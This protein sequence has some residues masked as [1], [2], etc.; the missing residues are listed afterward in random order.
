MPR[1]DAE[2]VQYN[3]GRKLRNNNESAIASMPAVYTSTPPL[4][5]FATIAAGIAIFVAP[6]QRSAGLRGTMWVLAGLAILFTYWRAGKLEHLIPPYRALGIAALA[7]LMAATI[8]SFASP[9]PLESLGAVKRDILTPML[10][11]A[12]FYALTKTRADM[13]RWLWALTLGLLVLT[14]MIVIEPFDP[15]GGM[16]ESHYITVGMLSA[17]IV[18]LAPLLA[19]SL[20]ANRRSRRSARVL[21]IVALP[22]LLLSAWLS[23]N[24]AV[25]VCFAGMLVVA[26]LMATRGRLAALGH[27]R[28]SAVALVLLALMLSFM[29][30]AM[31]FR[32][33]TQAPNGLGPLAF[34]LQDNR[35]P[36]L[37]VTADMIA[38]RPL[39]GYGY[40]NAEIG[41]AFSARL[42]SP[43]LKNYVRHAHNVVLDY[44]LQMGLTGAIV[45][46]GLFAALAWTFIT[47]VPLGGLA[48]LAGLCGVALVVGVFLRNMTDDFFSRH[49][50]QFFGAAVG[51]LL[52]LATH[53]PPL[54]LQRSPERK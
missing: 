25:W 43:W 7:W 46:L 17:W 19:L 26:T 9:T 3:G 21:L 4:M 14:I 51:M 15:L 37:R 45:I 1:V 33:R 16:Q 44:A 28:S 20:F 24:R 41:A 40:A 12:V 11:F 48:R 52:G 36:I 8:W 54:S 47:R 49:S 38:E 27:R 29:I 2:P 35:A 6:F 13:M 34:M 39:L 31:Q 22:C 32:A 18:M 42:E 50:A 10:A 30:A 5:R 23:G 53:R